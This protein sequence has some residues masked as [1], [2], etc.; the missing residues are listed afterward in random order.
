MYANIPNDPPNCAVQGCNAANCPFEGFHKSYNITCFHPAQDFRLR[1][2]TPLS[3][4]PSNEPDE[5]QEYFFNFGYQGTLD[6]PANING[7]LFQLPPVSLA[8]QSEEVQR[9][10]VVNRCSSVEDEY[11]CFDGCSCTQII[12]IPYDKTIRFVLTSIGEQTHPIHLHGHSFWVVASGY[13]QYDPATGFIKRSTNALTCL[14]NQSDFNNTDNVP[15]TTVQ[16]RDGYKP[17]ITLNSSTPRRDTILVP[18]G[19]YVVIQFRSTN[20]GFWFLHCHIEEHLLEGMALVVSVDP[21]RQNPPPDGMHTC[22]NFN[23]TLDEYRSKLNFD[24]SSSSSFGSEDDDEYCHCLNQAQLVI[25]V[26]FGVFC[27]A[28][29]VVLPCLC[30]AVLCC[31]VCRKKKEKAIEMKTVT[32]EESSSRYSPLHETS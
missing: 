8:M 20:P 6:L 27:V 18:A 32:N 2:P 13:G 19:G 12:E 29:F 25:A 3:E 28:V 9:E 14:K 23:W 5:G 17:N 16:W 4:L 26:V 15:C 22:G 30:S 24:P 11:S 21:S 10:G 1:Y 31:L 7:R